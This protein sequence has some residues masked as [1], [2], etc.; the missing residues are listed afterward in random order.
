MH[1]TEFK[2]SENRTKL[3]ETLENSAIELTF[4]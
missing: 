1:F 3:K 4:L 2:V